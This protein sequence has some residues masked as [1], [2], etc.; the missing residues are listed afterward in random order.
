MVERKTKIICTIGP[1]SESEEMLRA[2]IDGGMNVA[3]LNFSHGTHEEHALR[4]RGIRRLAGESGRPVA[5]MLDTKGPEIRTGTLESGTVELVRGNLLVLTARDVP[6]DEKT[7]SISY[8]GLPGEISPGDII[9]LDDGLIRL[10]VLAVRGPDMECR[11]ENGGRISSRRG[12]NIPGKRILLPF[13]SAKDR[14]DILFAIR[15]ELD[16]IALSFVRGPEDV[17]AVRRILEEHSSPIRI[18]AKIENMSAV[19][20]L[21]EILEASDGL[22]VARG[23]LGV[24]VPF[25][26]IPFLQKKI[27]RAANEAG[28]PVITA[29]Q[30]LDSMM[31]NPRPTRAEVTDVA[32]AILDGTD[33]VMLSGESAAGQ[34]PLESLQTL[35]KIA[36]E[37]EKIQDWDR[38]SQRKKSVLSGHPVTESISRAAVRITEKL[39]VSAIVV[40]TSSGYTPRMVAKYRPTVPIIAAV[41]DPRVRRQ[42][43]MVWGVETVLVDLSEDTDGTI[44]AAVEAARRAGF[45]KTGDLTVITAGVPCAVSGTTNMIRV[46]QV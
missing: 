8:A 45:V 13:L 35:V 39:D 9:L 40:P 23:D 32:N 28:K 46:H 31:R 4:V 43:A 10:T 29:T 19:S 18:V 38:S 5:I 21:E 1:A 20:A 41:W 36:L 25:E 22:M 44:A 37:T 15:E 17:L 3:R 42:L 24:E 6:G 27:I 33:C 26:E 16:F 30:M 34:Y 11:I 7:I 12:V 2:M 14:E